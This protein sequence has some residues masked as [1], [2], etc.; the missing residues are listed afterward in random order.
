VED[1]QHGIP[2]RLWERL[3]DAAGIAAESRWSGLSP[4][5]LQALA[6]QMVGTRLKIDGRA[7]NKAEWVTSGGVPLHEVDPQSMQSRMRAKLF[8]AGEILDIDGLAGGYNLQAA[9]TTARVAAQGV[10]AAAR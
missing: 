5:Q 10:A 2:Q 9:W 3:V 4:S 6:G 7:V 8:F 1:P